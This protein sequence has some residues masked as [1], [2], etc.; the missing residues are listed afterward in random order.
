MGLAIAQKIAEIHQG[1]IEVES[2][3]GSGSTF[4]V[5]LPY[6]EP[7]ALPTPTPEIEAIL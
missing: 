5:V 3:V 1:R 4:R 2:T 7:A 6:V